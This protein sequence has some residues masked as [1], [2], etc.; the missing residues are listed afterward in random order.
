MHIL[1]LEGGARP[2]SKFPSH[3]MN[4]CV[5]SAATSSDC[6][7]IFHAHPANLM[8]PTCVL[9]LTARDFTHA[10]WKSAAER[11]VVFP[12]GVGVVPW[13]VPGGAD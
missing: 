13:M 7:V 11:P 3:Y 6:R 4:H 5:R 12:E 1:G 9:P 2:T 8:A 10:L